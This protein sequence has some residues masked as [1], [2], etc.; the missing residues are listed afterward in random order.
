MIFIVEHGDVFLHPRVYPF[1]VFC[2]LSDNSKFCLYVIVKQINKFPWIF[3]TLIIRNYFY[4]WMEN[5]PISQSLLMRNI[6]CCGILFTPA[7]KICILFFKYF[8]L[9]I[10]LFLNVNIN[11]LAVL[12]H[13]CVMWDL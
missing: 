2:H 11:F 6:T 1:C 12:G 13:S 10:H 5:D 8:K 4:Y 3:K 7:T 9:I